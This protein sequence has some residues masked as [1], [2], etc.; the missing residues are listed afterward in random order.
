MYKSECVNTNLDGQTVNVQKYHLAQ[1]AKEHV[2]QIQVI[3]WKWM[4]GEQP[5]FRLDYPI[6]K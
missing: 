3:H 2:I 1:E 4:R 6:E 5:S